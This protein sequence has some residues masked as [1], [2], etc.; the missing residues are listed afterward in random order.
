MRALRYALLLGLT[1]SLPACVPE[2]KAAIAKAVVRVQAQPTAEARKLAIRNQL[3]AICPTPLP[4]ASLNRLADFL[5]AHKSDPRAFDVVS[6]LERM[7]AETAI[8][9]RGPK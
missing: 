7:D 1:I 2:Q 8:C 5:E 4:P 3:A 9:R 6:D